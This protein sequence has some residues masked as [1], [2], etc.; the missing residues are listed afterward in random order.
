MCFIYF[1]FKLRLTFKSADLKLTQDGR[2]A[3]SNQMKD[4]IEQ[5]TG[6]GDFYHQ[7]A[8]R[9][10]LPLSLNLQTDSLPCQIWD[11][12]SLHSHVNQFFSASVSTYPPHALTCMFTHARACTH[13]HTYPGGFIFLENSDKPIREKCIN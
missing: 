5:K 13:T 11:L 7:M 4:R 3:L 10:E 12:S 6:K 9:L 8:F 2:W 1:Y